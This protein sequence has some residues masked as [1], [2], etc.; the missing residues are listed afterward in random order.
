MLVLVR[1]FDCFLVLVPVLVFVFA[2]AFVCGLSVVIRV[3]GVYIMFVSFSTVGVVRLFCCDCVLGDGS[4]ELH[5]CYYL[6]A[7]VE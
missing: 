4:H 5:L 3:F 7:F 2:S 6:G 1:I